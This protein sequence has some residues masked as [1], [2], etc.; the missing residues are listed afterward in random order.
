MKILGMKIVED[1]NGRVDTQWEMD[2][3][4]LNHFAAIGIATV[5]RERAEFI[6]QESLKG[7]KN[8]LKKTTKKRTKK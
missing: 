3:E 6:L 5:I 7:E 1:G 4:A 8:T 2:E